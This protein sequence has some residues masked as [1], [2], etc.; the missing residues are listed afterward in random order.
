[1]MAQT[2]NLTYNALSQILYGSIGKAAFNIPAYSGGSRGHSTVS[3]S[4][5]EADAKAYLYSEADSM[6]SYFANTPTIGHGTKANPY[7]QRGGT[8]PPGHYTCVYKANHPPFGECVWL[9]RGAD[10]H[11]HFPTL[12]GANFD[13]RGNDFYIHGSGPK[14]SDGCI[15][16]RDKDERHRLNRAIRDFSQS[17]SV[18][19]LVKNVGYLLPAERDD[20]WPG[21]LA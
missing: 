13:N 6:F 5:A 9:Q 4:K 3:A 20:I 17:G 14:G 15:V 8:L 10:T 19:L 16:I 2:A 7:R 21:A 11:M 18:I 1:M 12:C